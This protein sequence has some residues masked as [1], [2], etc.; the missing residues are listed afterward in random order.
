MSLEAT[1]TTARRKR[2]R[3]LALLTAA[4]G[5]LPSATGFGLSSVASRGAAIRS[6]SIAADGALGSTSALERL[7][8]CGTQ[9]RRQQ[10]PRGG[11]GRRM[12]EI[13][14]RVQTPRRYGSADW[15]ANI[16][17]LPKSR[18]L[19]NIKE[20]LFYNTAFAFCVSMVHYLTPQHVIDDLHVSPIP[21]S[22]MSGALG[23][24][25]VFRTN[26][27][28]NRFWEARKIWGG[29][30][31]QCRNIARL[32]TVALGPDSPEWLEM[33]EYLRLYPFLLKQHLQDER[34]DAEMDWSRLP[35]GTVARLQDDPNPPLYCCQIMMEILA[36]ACSEGGAAQSPGGR[37]PDYT[38]VMY[39][40]QIEEG[41]SFLVDALGK[42]ERIVTTPVPRGYSR[43]TSRFLTVYGFTLPIVLVPHTELFTAPVV[44]AVCWGLF[45]IEEIAY[46]IE[47]PFDP[48]YRQLDLVTY[49]TKV[50]VDVDRLTDKSTVGR[51]PGAAAPQLPGTRRGGGAGMMMP[52][53][54]HQEVGLPLVDAGLSDT[55]GGGN[56]KN[57]GSSSSSSSSTINGCASGGNNG[58]D[59]SERNGFVGS[60]QQKQVGGGSRG[61]EGGSSSK[62]DELS[63]CWKGGPDDDIIEG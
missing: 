9:H 60:Q 20:H 55:R 57:N 16:Q 43:H 14:C 36:R 44:A 26:A 11:G 22:I 59:M 41:L 49:A 12:H 30:I 4:F 7:A 50:K 31:N 63:K 25:L 45:S 24:L 13:T 52:P 15:F 10:Q 33:K 46:F 3:V 17:N 8:R 19:Y 35:E 38:S 54:S 39:R 1:A 51:R 18:L 37:V 28:Y 32:S 2:P 58:R 47:Q 48:E 5:V 21:H 40:V 56:S 62:V 42:C 27:A 61:A 53:S 6:P 29:L 23:L 34:D